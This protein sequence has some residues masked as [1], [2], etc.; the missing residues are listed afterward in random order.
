[1]KAIRHLDCVGRPLPTTFGISTGAIA[2]DDLDARVAA[3]PVGEHVGSAIVEQIDRSVRLKIHQQRAVAALLAAQGNIV[4]TQ[5]ARAA[6]KM[7]ILKRM[8]DPQER[9]RADG[10][11]DLPRKASAT[12]TASLQGKGREQLSGA[13]RPTSVAS[14]GTIEAL[15]EDLA[16]AGRCVAEP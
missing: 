1:M 13:V 6:L 14:Q 10:H 16:R 8:Q 2:D 15:S 12:F 11:T 4:N 3:E 7:V 5:H 9:I